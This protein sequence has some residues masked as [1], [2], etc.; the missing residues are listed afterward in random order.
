MA[1]DDNGNKIEPGIIQNFWMPKPSNNEDSDDIMRYIDTQVKYAKNYEYTVY[2]YQIVIG[3]NY[4]FQIENNF[5]GD[6]L[7]QSEIDYAAGVTNSAATEGYIDS[8]LEFLY[9]R[10]GSPNLRY[11]RLFKKPS[12]GSRITYF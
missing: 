2:A 5:L 3:S 1:I 12:E 9:E 7:S 4:G 10:P 11:N 6:D 8:Q